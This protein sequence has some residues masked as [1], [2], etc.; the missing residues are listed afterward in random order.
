[1]ANNDYWAYLRDNNELKHYRTK[2]SKNGYTKDP[3]Y[4]PVGQKAQTDGGDYG[5]RLIPNRRYNIDLSSKHNTTGTV[6]LKE[7]RPGVFGMGD[8]VNTATKEERMAGDSKVSAAQARGQVRQQARQQQASRAAK[9][10]LIERGNNGGNAGLR[11]LILYKWNGR[12]HEEI[13]YDKREKE[14]ADEKLKNK[15][16][17]WRESQN[18][19]TEAKIKKAYNAAKEKTLGAIDSIKRKL[20]KK[21]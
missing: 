17:A 19:T 6:P 11:P 7:V 20:A 3:N 8:R 12:D 10:R 15:Q 2:G 9:E 16:L 1:M 13:N 14:R 21:R 18:Q 4:T 5:D